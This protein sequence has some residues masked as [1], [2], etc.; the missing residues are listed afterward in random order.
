MFKILINVYNNKVK[1]LIHRKLQNLKEMFNNPMINN[2]TGDYPVLHK[3][4][5][6]VS[7]I[8]KNNSIN[9]RLVNHYNKARTKLH[10]NNCRNLK[11]KVTKKRTTCNFS[12]KS[13]KTC[14]K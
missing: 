2:K 1:E 3:L 13:F 7:S 8:N 4:N 14:N 10:R 6:I 12:H 11:T 9:H 5:T